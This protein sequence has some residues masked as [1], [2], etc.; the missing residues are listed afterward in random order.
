MDFVST[1]AGNMH[2][3]EPEDCLSGPYV[4]EEW[5]P[6]VLKKVVERLVVGEGFRWVDLLIS[7]RFNYYRML[8]LKLGFRIMLT[9]STFESQGWQKAAWYGTEYCVEDFDDELWNVSRLLTDRSFI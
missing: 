1:V 3:Y 8:V 2:V 7:F 9:S 6:E 5:R 4:V